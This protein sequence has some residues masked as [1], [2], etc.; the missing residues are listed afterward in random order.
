MQNFKHELVEL[1]YDDLIA[2]TTGSGRIYKDPDGKEYP[3][4]TTVLK[5]LSEE[6]IQAWRAR[7]GEEEANRV[8]R[9]ASTR[10]TTV[11]NMIE[12]YI[13]NDP[14]FVKVQNR[15]S[16]KTFIKTEVTQ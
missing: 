14:E 2:E 3:S 7:V 15:Y 6:K 10:G 9:I 5:I 13:A 1:G 4:V 8:S 12:K 16:T 11:H